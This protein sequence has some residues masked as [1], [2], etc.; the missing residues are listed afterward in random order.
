MDKQSFVWKVAGAAGE[1]I[2]TTGLLFSKI[3]ARH[4][5][6][7]FDYPEYPSLIKGG[8]NTYQVHASKT[9]VYSQKSTVDLLVAL[10]KDALKLH[11]DELTED[12]FI[13]YDQEDDK[14]DIAKYNLKAKTINLPMV[15]LAK[16]AGAEKVMSNNVALGASICFFGLDLGVLDQL[17]ANIFA[18]KK[19]EVI[20]LNKRCATAGYNFLKTQTQPPPQVVKD[21]AVRLFTMTGN[22]AIALGALAGGLQF[23]TS[24]PMTPSSSILHVLAEKAKDTKIVVKHAEDEIG[25]VNMA[26]GASFAGTRSMTGTSGGGFCYM[27]E[28]LGLSGI[29]ELP[30]VI[31]ESMRPGPALGMP[32][33]TAQGDIK[34]I[35]SASHDEFPRFVLAP[36]DAKEAFDLSR[37]AMELAEKYQ[38]PVILCSDKYLSESR[39]S[40]KFESPVFENTRFGF[41]ASPVPDQTGFYPRYEENDTGI[42][43]RSTPGQ[44]DGIHITNSYEHDIYGFS[45]EDPHVRKSQQDK[46]F[47]KL[48]KM[49]LEIPPQFWDGEPGSKI[50]FIS[51]G[52]T[53]GPLCQAR[54]LLKTEGI[55]TNMLNLS[56]LT[57]FPQ[58]QVEE[59]IKS[60]Q[61]IVV[62]EENSQG[63]LASLITQETGIKIKNRLNRY[64]GRPFY[65]EEIVDFV[66]NFKGET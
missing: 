32:T 26:L 45:T 64:D 9:P 53:K 16:E 39:Y 24:Y 22:E 23:Y 17:I 14:I 12:T 50:T 43:Q 57:P 20:S 34:F 1:G 48:V 40:L 44:T 18:D 5:L 38:T 59:A 46:R 21:E 30:L 35:I 41:T 8:H 15:K 3:C 11:Q 65:P 2:M 4:G 55:P 10:N 61:N 6:Y 33:W 36:G 58:K 28:A 29:A 13:F 47:K 66:K 52:S 31:V 51:F 7:V 54:N 60:S 25:A 56:W 49:A 27:V 42:S 19:P 63:Q 37:K 62:V